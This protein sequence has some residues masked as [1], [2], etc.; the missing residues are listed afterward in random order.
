MV[1]PGQDDGDNR[2]L[3][4]GG[5]QISS[6]VLEALALSPTLPLRPLLS[7]PLR[8]SGG[9]SGEPSQ[10]GVGAGGQCA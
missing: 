9:E 2:G 4:T 1:G 10:M 5:V 7:L 3:G 6:V 8:Q